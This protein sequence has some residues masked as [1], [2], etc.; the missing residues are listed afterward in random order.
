MVEPR[1]LCS[2]LLHELKIAPGF[3][4]SAHIFQVP[5]RESLHFRKFVNQIREQTIDYPGSPAF[6]FLPC[7][8]IVPDLPGEK[9]QFAVYG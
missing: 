7:Q 9:D 5:D 2:N 6:P 4:K 3:G 1:Y 8:D